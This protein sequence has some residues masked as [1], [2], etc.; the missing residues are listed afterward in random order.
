M[1]ND[2][3]KDGFPILPDLR[4]SLCHTLLAA[5]FVLVGM[6]NPFADGGTE[7]SFHWWMMV[8]LA[9]SAVMSWSYVFSRWRAW[10]GTPKEI[11]A[12]QILGAR[13]DRDRARSHA[14]MA[15]LSLMLTMFA[16][17]GRAAIPDMHK[18]LLHE[19]LFYTAAFVSVL[20]TTVL[21]RAVRDLLF[22][23]KQRQ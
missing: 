22:Q 20:S 9:I 18:S 6:L 8:V 1:E 12:A 19:I 14:L 23:R 2:E 16:F 17:L 15:A 11:K 10:R 3:A 7:A 4:Q 13:Q 5:A 21:S